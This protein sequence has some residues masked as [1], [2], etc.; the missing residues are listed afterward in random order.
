[1]KSLII[2]LALALV[3]APAFAETGRTLHLVL[4]AKDF[5]ELNSKEFGPT[6]D[7]GTGASHH[8]GSLERGFFCVKETRPGGQVWSVPYDIVAITQPVIAPGMVCIS[9]TGEN[10]K[11]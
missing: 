11:K 4:C 10:K 3:S 7:Q 1:M 9:V 6:C 2:A 5:V 8:N